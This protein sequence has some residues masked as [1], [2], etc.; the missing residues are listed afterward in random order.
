MYDGII[1]D[2][3]GTLADTSHIYADVCVRL[4]RRHGFPEPSRQDLERMRE[5][6][7][8]QK[9]R[10][11]RVPSYRLPR[12]VS[13]AMA[14]YRQLIETAVPYAGIK[15]L[16]Q[17]L[18]EENKA[19]YIVS[20]NSHETIQHFLSLHEM[21]QF[22]R[23]EGQASLFGKHLSLRKLVRQEKLANQ[24]L[25]YLGDEIRDIHACRKTGLPVGAVTWGY[26]SKTILVKADPDYIFDQPA[27][28]LDL[29]RNQDS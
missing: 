10:F 9:L 14:L 24:S 4:A 3:D 7:L 13:E 11:F 26:E 29:L 5:L 6:T 21:D 19:C 18:S 16:V 28:V 27:D 1:F 15:A 23:I 25:L 12:L 17:H 2:F 8:A 22:N 20:S